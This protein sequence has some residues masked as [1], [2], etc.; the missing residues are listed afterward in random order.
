M[1]SLPHITL[2]CALLVPFGAGCRH[3]APEPLSA[4]RSAAALRAR[5]LQDPG[6][7]EFMAE[8]L[9][10]APEPW[11][12]ERWGLAD[13]TLAALFFQP[14]MRVVEAAADV[15]AA[16]VGAAGQL[17]N[18]TVSVLPQRLSNPSGGI[19]PW[20]AAVQVDWTL[21]TAGKRRHRRAA[22]QARA[23]AAAL[24]IPA[25]AWGLRGRLLDALVSLAAAEAR[26]A[27][28]AQARDTQAHLVGLLEARLRAGAVDESRVSLQRLALARMRADAARS[29]RQA[30]EARAGLAS[31]LGVSVAALEGVEI[32][33][34]LSEIPQDLAALESGKAQRAALLGRADVL[35]MLSRYAASEE[36]LRLELAKQV[37]DLHLGPAYEFD[38]GDNKWGLALSLELPLLSQ[39]QG[40]IDEALARRR[41]L[42]ARFERLQARVIGAVDA[43]LASLRGSRAELREARHLVEGARARQRLTRAALS[44]GATDRVALLHTDLEVQRASV[45][46]IDSEEQLQN[47]AAR[48]EQAVQPREAFAFRAPAGLAP[49]PSTQETP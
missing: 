33:F 7:R 3:V 24:A 39:N 31:V 17:P 45:L 46:L 19:S 14:E 29:G 34:S 5:N 42:A 32:D 48:L 16:H 26:H 44:E 49:E 43:A 20:L 21:E 41:E 38:Q 30:L 8:Q 47:A 36:D 27:N 4:A 13:L 23:G 12:R 22:A 18:P 40:S 6:L 2:L 37:P 9:G 35:A 10:H 28:Q 11:P 25:A 15:A 1:R